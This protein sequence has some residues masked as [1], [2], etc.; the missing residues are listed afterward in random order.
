MLSYHTMF[1]FGKI[2]IYLSDYFTFQVN[3]TGYDKM[4]KHLLYLGC[5]VLPLVDL[6]NDSLA[7]SRS[8]WISIQGMILIQ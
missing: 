5:F 4:N 1:G 6:Y 7:I 8:L 2:L 3:F